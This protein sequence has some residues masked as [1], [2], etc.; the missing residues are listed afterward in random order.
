[1]R[2]Q[3]FL[4]GRTKLWRVSISRHLIKQKAKFILLNGVHSLFGEHGSIGAYLWSR[5]TF[6]VGT[7]NSAAA[8]TEEERIV[9]ETAR[10][11]EIDLGTGSLK[12]KYELRAV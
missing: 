2:E 6:F 5:A 3:E 8:A 10:S 4:F 9:F 11:G 12:H 7:T 1:M